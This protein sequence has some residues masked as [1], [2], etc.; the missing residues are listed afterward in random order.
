MKRLGGLQHKSHCQRFTFSSLIAY[1]F[2][3]L[4]QI[5]FCYKMVNNLVDV[6]VSSP[7]HSLTAGLPEATV[8]SSRSLTVILPGMQGYQ[9]LKLIALQ[10]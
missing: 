8:L 2:D 3:V 1:T 6:N 5:Y 7:S 10:V 4:R 9:Y